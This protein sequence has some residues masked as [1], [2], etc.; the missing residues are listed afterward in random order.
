MPH[1]HW[2]TTT[3]TAG[4]RRSGHVA[5]RSPDFNPMKMAFVKLKV[6]LGKVAARTTDDLWQVIAGVLDTFSPTECANYFAATGY[7]QV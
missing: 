2:K 7:Y 6:L 4:L 5:P 3:F 1:G